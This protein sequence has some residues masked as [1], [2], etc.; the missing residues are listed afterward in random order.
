MIL[1]LITKPDF[2]SCNKY[3]LNSK[4][5]KKLR[6]KKIVLAWTI[7]NKNDLDKYRDLADNF[8]CENIF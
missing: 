4:R 7:K 5:I 3:Y 8:I 1:N 2:I 6:N